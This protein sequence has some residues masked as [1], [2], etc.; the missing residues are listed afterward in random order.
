MKKIIIIGA[1]PAGLAAA[2]K[3]CEHKL[4]PI[5]LEKDSCVAGI[6][7]TVKYKGYYFDIGGHRFFS[8]NKSVFNWWHDIL[9]EDFVRTRRRYKIK[10]II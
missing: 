4:N 6:S 7:R 9:G 1:G 8:K 2:D 5:V 3:L 10:R